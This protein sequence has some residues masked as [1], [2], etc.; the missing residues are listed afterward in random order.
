MIELVVAMVAGARHENCSSDE[1]CV[2]DI[3]VWVRQW[4]GWNMVF[5]M[6]LELEVL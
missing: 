1:D 6:V 2:G 3:I 4:C 5:L